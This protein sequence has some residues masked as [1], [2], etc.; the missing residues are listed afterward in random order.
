MSLKNDEL[1]IFGKPV[2]AF[3]LLVAVAMLYGQ[4]LWNPIVFDDKPFFMLG[5]HELDVYLSFTPW[6]L[7]WLPYATLAWTQHLLGREL[8]WFRLE[9][10]ALHAAT[11]IALFLFLEHLFG[12]VL[13]Q[14]GAKPAGMPHIWLAFF[15]ALFFVWHP[16]A[17]YGAAYLIQRT[18]VMAT[19]FS[20]LA[21]YAYMRGLTENRPRWLWIS[22]VLYCVA[23]FSKE[24]SVM[25]PAVML[26][27]TLLLE[28]PSAALGKRL[29]GVYAACALIAFFVLFQK[30][31]LVGK[32]YEINAPE[33]LHEIEVKH[34]YFLSILTQSFLFFK[35]WWLWLLPDPGWMSVDMR[36]PFATKIFSPYL[37]ALPVFLA[38][39]LIGFRLLLKRGEL[40]LLGFAMLF[41][42][43]MFATE[44][45]VV[46][47]Q[48][49]FVLYRSYLWMAGAFAVLP[50]LV[51]HLRLRLAFVGLACSALVL[52]A[53]AVNRLATFSHPL[54]LW[55]DAEV[56][57]HNRQGL[58]GADRIYY[59]LGNCLLD[60]RR[61]KE[62]LMDYQT[63]VALNPDYAPNHYGAALGYLNMENFAGARSEFNKTIEIAP[64]FVKAYY[65]RGLANY[66]LGHLVAAKAD[67]E[68]SCEMGWERGCAKVKMLDGKN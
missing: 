25:L 45:S 54:L 50:F 15:G 3:L 48:E 13:K 37:L 46:R 23:V 44:F 52:A 42:W 10:L 17:V 22:V 12:L 31:G 56:L 38:Y 7:R 64:D 26:M 47:I 51:R 60:L 67:F 16:V 58:I 9:S 68:K 61:Y 40:G 63:A 24:H 57:V 49:S 6:K 19:L 8:I 34:A 41:P 20:L 21:L 36:E 27:L 14:D 62:S 65:G 53:L 18:I 66:K 35:Y 55:E 29:W 28:P 33:M 39:G 5:K 59:N 32:V 30:L 43:L 11:G 1:P 2:F 4:F